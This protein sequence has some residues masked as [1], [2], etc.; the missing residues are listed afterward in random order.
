MR[1]ILFGMNQLSSVVK[2]KKINT[3]RFYYTIHDK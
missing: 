3:E 2:R 1:L